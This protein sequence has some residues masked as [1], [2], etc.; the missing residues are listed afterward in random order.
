MMLSVVCQQIKTI[1][2]VKKS[3][4]NLSVLPETRLKPLQKK[5]FYFPLWIFIATLLFSSCS[6]TRNIAED[7][8]FLKKSAVTIIHQ[9]GARPEEKK[10]LGDLSGS[11]TPQ[12][13]HPLARWRNQFYNF[14][15]KPATKKGIRQFF[16]QKVGKEPVVFHPSDT[17]TNSK[18]LLNFLTE[19][20]FFRATIRSTFYTKNRKASVRYHVYTGERYYIRDIIF[21]PDSLICGTNKE[22][23]ATDC[24]LQPG[25]P[26]LL[27][28]IRQFQEKMVAAGQEN[29][30]FAL[31]KDLIK[32]YID[33]LPN[34]NKADLYINFEIDR[35]TL[36]LHR[37]K[38]GET[39][40]YP[41]FSLEIAYHEE[42]KDTVENGGLTFIYAGE[43]EITPSILSASVFLREG[44]YYNK[45]EVEKSLKQLQRLGF[46]NFINQ[47]LETVQVNNQPILHRRILLNPSLPRKIEG[48][49]AV[50]TRTGN[51]LGLGANLGYEHRNIWKKL[52]LFNMSLRGALETQIGDR[53]G[54][55]N[56]ASAGAEI[57][58]KLPWLWP[59]RVV[60]YTQKE[61]AFIPKTIFSAGLSYQDRDKFYR[62]AGINLKYGHQWQSAPNN[63]H[64]LFFLQINRLDILSKT[65]ALQN[66]LLTNPLLRSSFDDQYL[67]GSLYRFDWNS[68][69]DKPDKAYSSLSLT[70]ESSGNLIY[71]SAKIFNPAANKKFE[72]LG[73]PF[74]QFLKVDIDFR[75]YI[76]LNS[77]KLA[78][79]FFF[80]AGVPYGN[81]DILPY[82]KQYF[83]GGST[84][85][86]AFP[87]RSVGPG[88]YRTLS[89]NPEENEFID[90]TGDLKL[91]CNI[92]Y[93][94]PLFS[95][96]EGAI[97]ADAGNI[98]LWQQQQEERAEGIFNWA[99]FIPEIAIGS[100]VGLRA[101]FN[102]LIIRLDL[103]TPLRVPYLDPKSRWVFNSINLNN[104]AW[105]KENL[106]WNLALG[107]PF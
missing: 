29:G 87:I 54:F 105:R 65:E 33:T 28:S 66:L 58:F 102:T 14:W 11:M 63:K 5:I 86:R 90:Q 94:F 37:F 43:K 49:L 12:P 91:E 78:G 81:A 76:P 45:K 34:S 40:V 85:I 98:W 26:V 99:E 1:I 18:R 97:F 67:I 39:I 47:Q 57:N 59:F 24:A 74:S 56:S 55:I 46:F 42:T 100:G 52:I 32:C 107:Y 20:G 7:K 104:A 21:S 60:R 44:D 4:F 106:V 51:F 88:N 10:T 62:I 83:S 89:N 3:R 27:R 64:E 95:Y 41:D 73:S 31:E 70:A 72:F 103:A 17:T 48:G 35:D 93:R 16:Q 71:L 23:I 9:G 61:D 8:F 25:L 84:G 38:M 68:R 92:E 79:R 13:D 50:D 96:V 53:A 30:C 80:G 15:G 19:A 101:G 22:N 69:L 82:L 77:G 36:A 2:L 75:H 6:L